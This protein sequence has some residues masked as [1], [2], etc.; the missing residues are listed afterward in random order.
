MRMSWRTFVLILLAAIWPQLGCHQVPAD[1]SVQEL[2]PIQQI[3][4]AKKQ[5]LTAA[6]IMLQNPA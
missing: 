2:R 5:D 4:S 3:G 6:E 1:K